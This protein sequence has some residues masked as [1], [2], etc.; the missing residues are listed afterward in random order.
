MSNPKETK[1]I[2]HARL[3][4]DRVDAEKLAILLRSGFLPQVWIAPAPVRFAK[5]VL[6]Y[7]TLL[8]GMRTKLRNHLGA[9]LLRK[10][11]RHAPGQSL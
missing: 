10:R 5:E 3:K 1:A 6:R 4:N 11:N 9:M 7:R 2:A 8:V